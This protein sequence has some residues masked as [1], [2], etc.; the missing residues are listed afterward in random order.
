MPWPLASLLSSRNWKSSCG[1]GSGG[2]SGD[3]KRAVA[4]SWWLVPLKSQI[5]NE[6]NNILLLFSAN[7]LVWSGLK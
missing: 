1:R 7:I 2:P 3:G 5:K 6:F 4:D